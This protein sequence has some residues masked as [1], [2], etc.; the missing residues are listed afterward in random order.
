MI[1]H[2][3]KQLQCHLVPTGRLYPVPTVEATPDM[4]FLVIGSIAINH[5]VHI[6]SGGFALALRPN[7]KVLKTK[8]LQMSSFPAT[9][10]W[11]VPAGTNSHIL[12]SYSRREC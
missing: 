5:Y 10:K 4:R 11:V 2:P 8:V 7:S 6:R 3:C 12:W 1:L 9:A